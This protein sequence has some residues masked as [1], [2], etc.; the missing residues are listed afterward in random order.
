MSSDIWQVVL[1]D[2]LFLCMAA[3]M[4][5][6]FRAW[7]AREQQRLDRRLDALEAQ[8]ARLE[9][10]SGRLQTVSR[11]LELMGREG[12]EGLREKRVPTVPEARP[13][14]S[15]KQE[16]D[17]EQAWEMLSAGVEPVVVAQRLGIGVAEVELMNRMMRYRRQV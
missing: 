7:L 5:L 4:G 16:A 10:V 11:V 9:R 2:A 17:F 1:I 3:G 15:S 13:V 14:P 12:G 6:W 8:H